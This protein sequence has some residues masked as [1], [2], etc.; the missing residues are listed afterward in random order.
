MSPIR[1]FT[2]VF[3]AQ[4]SPDGAR[5]FLPTTQFDERQQIVGDRSYIKG[6]HCS[7]S[8]G[9]FSRIFADSCSAST[10]LAL[11]R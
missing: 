8:V 5:N 7:N 6:N 4:T 10:S 2:N 1:L 3:S 11:T 9:S